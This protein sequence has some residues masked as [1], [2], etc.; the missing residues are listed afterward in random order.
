MCFSPHSC[1]LSPAERNDRN[2]YG[3]LSYYIQCGVCVTALSTSN[4]IVFNVLLISLSKLRILECGWGGATRLT[5][6]KYNI[7]QQFVVEFGRVSVKTDAL[8]GRGI[9][10]WS[11]SLRVANNTSVV[12]HLGSIQI[13]IICLNVPYINDRLILMGW[14]TDDREG[15]LDDAGGQQHNI[16]EAAPNELKLGEGG[17]SDDSWSYARRWRREVFVRRR[18][19]MQHRKFGAF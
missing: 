12:E 15:V 17:R 7:C 6:T 3:L 5:R 19:R 8:F 13:V 14:Y 16:T 1:A 10:K 2:H 11:S 9:E 4:D 18:L